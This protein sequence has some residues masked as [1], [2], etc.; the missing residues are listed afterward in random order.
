[1]SQ[2]HFV[3]LELGNKSYGPTK[4]STE[5][6]EDVDEFKKAI[7]KEWSPLLDTFASGQL[8]LFEG[9]GIS[10]IDPETEMKDVFVTKGKPLVVRV[11][12]F[13]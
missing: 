10:E 4:V 9:D 11:E 5:G 6:C 3:K 12:S 7:K 2:K 13:W 1:M 8:T